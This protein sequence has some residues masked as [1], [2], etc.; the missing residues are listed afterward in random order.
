M[1]LLYSRRLCIRLVRA[2][3]VANVRSETGYTVAEYTVAV[4][5]DGIGCLFVFASILYSRPFAFVLLGLEMSWLP[6]SLWSS[7]CGVDVLAHR[8]QHLE[9]EKEKN[10]EKKKR[11][12]R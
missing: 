8:C 4:S 7:L 5:T 12:A 10:K 3:D 1:N 9:E 11:T 6:H 2:G